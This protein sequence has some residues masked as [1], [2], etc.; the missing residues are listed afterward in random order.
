MV[1]IDLGGT[2][3]RVA[4]MDGRARM[5]E[6]DHQPTRAE[7]GPER[8]ADR[9]A[10]TARRMLAKHGLERPLAVGAALA[11][12]IDLD[13]VMYRPPNLDAWQVVPF[14]ALLAERFGAPV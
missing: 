6:R 12:P 2:N 10:E 3:L 1:A 13:G 7:D 14:G 11:S 4:L 5:L 8:V 9:I